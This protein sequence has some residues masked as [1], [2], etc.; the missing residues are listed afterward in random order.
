MNLV[1]KAVGWFQ[2][3]GQWFSPWN[4]ATWPAALRWFGNTGNAEGLAIV[5]GC[6]RIRGQIIG[7]VP[8]HLFREK[9][10]G[11]K[12]KADDDSLYD[13]L[14]AS[15]NE[16]TSSME[17]RTNLERSF[18]LW[19]NGY[20]HLN[21][22]EGRIVSFD[23]LPPERVQPKLERD[24][25]LYYKFTDYAGRPFEYPY[26]DVLHIRNFSND[27]IC[28][29]SPLL[30]YV[31]EHALAAQSFSSNFLKNA[32]R[33]AGV[34]Q[35]K[36]ARPTSDTEV[37]K[38]MQDWDAKYGGPANAGKTPVL[39]NEATYVPMAVPPDE[40]Q[41][42]ETARKLSGDI[43][44]AIYGVPLNLLG[45]ESQTSTF[46]S[47]EQFARQFLTFTIAPQCKL[48]E[49]ALNKALFR[50]IPGQP[51]R[52][53][54]SVEFDLDALQRGDS[55]AQAAFYSNAANNGWMTRNEIRAKQNLPALPGGD[56]LTV[57]S[58]LIPIGRLGEATTSTQLP[59]TAG[60]TQ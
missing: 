43:A 44:G 34:I 29:I 56:E 25:P 2:R 45:I 49:Q 12:I 40:A 13:L 20:A 37:E 53:G 16:Y 15:P 3:K 47:A 32:G 52:Q 4:T 28:G 35:Q 36:R 38:Y 41:L 26:Q 54:L 21:R 59:D 24:R 46:A 30:H 11:T 39:W 33:V 55:A 51:V 27:T 8:L 7:S 9:K 58:N 6:A 42:I 18:C 22:M 31:M 1:Q 10:S 48:Y 23:W 19:G 57:Q 17:L 50:V 60:G 14:H 5:Y